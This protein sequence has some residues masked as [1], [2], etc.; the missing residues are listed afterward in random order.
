MLGGFFYGG[1]GIGVGH[2]DGDWQ[3][4]P[5]YALRAGVDFALGGLDLDGYASYRFQS[6]GDLEGFGKKDLDALTF[7][8][9]I[10]FG[11]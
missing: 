10:R 6:T 8:A 9:L 4:E 1:V 11:R 5:F 3:D 2:I 7:G